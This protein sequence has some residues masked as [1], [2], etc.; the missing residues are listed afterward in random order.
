[1]NQV[2]ESSFLGHP[3]DG[4]VEY[5]GGTST[6]EECYLGGTLVAV[7]A[8]GGDYKG[9]SDFQERYSFDT[10]YPS[11]NF[12]DDKPGECPRGWICRITS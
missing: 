1:M 10:A 12:E 4:S 6:C 11:L 8:R 7:P 3:G 2:D 5:D 9:Y